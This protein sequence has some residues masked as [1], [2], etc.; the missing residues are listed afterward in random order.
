MIGEAGRIVAFEFQHQLSAAAVDGAIETVVRARVERQREHPFGI[1]RLD[2]ALCGVLQGGQGFARKQIVQQRTLHNP[3]DVQEFWGVLRKMRDEI[4]A[5]DDQH[6]A[7]G[8]DMA[9]LVDRFAV[10]ACQIDLVFGGTHAWA[11]AT[12]RSASA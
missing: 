6:R 10:A 5:R 11:T 12:C 9:Q 8:L 1:V 7:E 2:Q 4:V 3:L